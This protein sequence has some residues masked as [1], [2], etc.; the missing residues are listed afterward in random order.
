MQMRQAVFHRAAMK[1]FI[2]GETLKLFGRATA[3][4][5][6]GPTQEGKRV[7]LRREGRTWHL[8]L[9]ASPDLCH[10]S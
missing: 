9:W 7:V 1:V 8:H 6:M 3:P 2:C 4:A 10:R 5:R